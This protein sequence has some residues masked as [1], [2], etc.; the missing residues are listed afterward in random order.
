MRL[1]E[2][3][4]AFT[5]EKY[6]FNDVK[7]TGIV[8]DSRKAEQ[9]NLYICI[10]GFSADGH[11][12]AR[13]AVDNGAIALIS[14]RKLE[15]IDVPQ[16]IVENS[17]S[18]M[19]QCAGK[20]YG[21]PADKLKIVGIT[22]TNG[23][24]T[25]SHM[26]KRIFEKNNIKTAAIG[27]IGT[28]IG[29][30]KHSQSLTT[31]DPLQLHE[32]FKRANDKGCENLV[33]EVSAHALELNKLDGVMFEVGIFTNLTQDHLDDFGTMD[34]YE[35]AK[36]KLFNDKTTRCAVINVDDCSCDRM[37]KNFNNKTITYSKDAGSDFYAS[38]IILKSDGLS[39]NL[40]HDGEKYLLRLNMAGEFNVYNSLAAIAASVQSGIK[41]EDAVKGLDGIGNVDGRM[42]QVKVDAEFSVI[43]DYAHTPDSLENLLMSVREICRSR[44]IC[45][46][47]CGGDRDNL[48]RPIMG[49]ISGRLADYSIITSDNP[50]T[51]KPDSI[52]DMIEDG[53]KKVTN[54]YCR[55]E[56]RKEAIYKGLKIAE[57]GD[58]V[59]IAGKGHETY[60]DIMGKKY[61][62]DDRV[63]V[64][65]YME[66]TK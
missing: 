43:V 47:G 49:E 24:T 66:S 65:E 42:E 18:V 34:R 56:N 4:K 38:E 1:S 35:K 33:I 25:T 31:P 28:F 50:R 58:I 55:I 3:A 59:V 12:Y 8:F 9:G 13:A 15:D 64:K 14:Q 51:E 45:I 62:F 39:Y 17:R 41:I 57:I 10:Q 48:K 30:E 63:V 52:I 16:L 23:K 2:I 37:I 40:N 6:K 44:C 19:A 21:Y 7:I 36:C 20:W 32:I 11:K 54:N 46:F 22:G 29:D 27:T 26:I 60:Q 5:C 53:I 61:R